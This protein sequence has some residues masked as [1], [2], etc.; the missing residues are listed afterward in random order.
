LA[1]FDRNRL[2]KRNRFRAKK[3][4]K[5]LHLPEAGVRIRGNLDTVTAGQF[6]SPI[7]IAG[8]VIRYGF[9][10]IA[11]AVLSLIGISI[12]AL[13][14][15]PAKP[16]SDPPAFRIAS[17]TLGRL[18][19]SGHVVAGSRFGRAE[20]RQYGQLHNRDVDLAVVMIMPPKGVGMGTEF[21]QDLREVNLL[22]NTRAV[23]TS[24]RYDLDT[25]FGEFR[26][27]E[28]RV[29][30]D[31]RWKQCLAFRSRLEIA[32]VYLTGWYCDAT[33]SKPSADLLACMLDRFVL[34][35][36]LASKEADTFLRAR[37]ARPPRC[38]AVPVSQTTDTGHRSIPSPSRW[39]PNGQRRY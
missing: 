18:P 36:E 17:S 29:D 33:G 25:R 8:G 24:N 21:G 23:L 1:G 28:M 12:M 13:W 19:V 11:A 3:F 30:S 4:R 22:R 6:G 39:A 27:T 2:P 32:A 37:M 20:V 26:A 15:V 34:D 5:I 14:K 31:G 9:Y 35:T 7:A 38:Q 10:L 16:I